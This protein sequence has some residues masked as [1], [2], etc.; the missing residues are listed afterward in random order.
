MLASEV[1]FN[2]ENVVSETA[3]GVCWKG[4]SMGV[5]SEILEDIK[6]WVPKIVKGCN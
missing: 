1:V 3:S 2:G 5:I 6:G 4:L